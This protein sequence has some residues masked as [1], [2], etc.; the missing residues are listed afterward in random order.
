MQHKKVVLWGNVLVDALTDLETVNEWLTSFYRSQEI[1]DFDNNKEHREKL[2]D[3]LPFFITEKKIPFTAGCNMA[4][5]ATNLSFLTNNLDLHYIAPIGR[6]FEEEFRN[7]M[8]QNVNIHLIVDPT[9]ETYTLAGIDGAENNF[10]YNENAANGLLPEQLEI[11]SHGDTL[12][13]HISKADVFFTSGYELREQKYEA[14]QR[15]LRAVKKGAITVYDV[16]NYSMFIDSTKKSV[17]Q[18]AQY[19]VM[20]FSRKKSE[21]HDKEDQE[22]KYFLNNGTKILL[23]TYGGDGSAIF[24]QDQD[25]VQRID[26]PRIDNLDIEKGTTIGAGDAY[27]AAF[28]SKVFETIGDNDR[29]I[30]D[31]EKLT[32]ISQSPELLEE[33]GN[34]ASRVAS[35]KCGY[36]SV[37]LNKEMVDLLL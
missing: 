26:I 32:K 30:C 25:Q 20:L 29:A 14:T 12:E 36:E 17:E 27:I 7:S 19:D 37:R 9:K 11:S 34:Y 22:R 28:M 16:A 3:L 4:N 21:R 15:A 23:E 31:L 5:I 35:I 8:P 13:G 10:V 24:Y 1:G 6:N 2:T 18:G 33:F